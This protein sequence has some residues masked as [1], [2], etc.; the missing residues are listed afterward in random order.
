MFIF[1]C[2]L[3]ISFATEDKPCDKIL[4]LGSDSFD[5]VLASSQVL[6][7]EF[8]AKWCAH[9]R[10]FAP[11]YEVVSTILDEHNN[12]KL[13][14]VNIDDHPDLA[15]RF[16]VD[17][18]PTFKLF[19]KG[20]IID[21]TSDRDEVN[22]A[23]WIIKYSHPII[24]EIHSTE[25]LEGLKQ[26]HQVC[27]IMMGSK[28]SPQYLLFE[29]SAQ[30]S[31]SHCFGLI[32]DSN[33][34][35]YQTK[36]EACILVFKQNDDKFQINVRFDFLD[37]YFESHLVPWVLPLSDTSIKEI[38]IK[39]KTG[40]IVFTQDSQI[41]KLL[42]D[43]T[44]ETYNFFQLTF[45]DSKQALHQVL[46]KELGVDKFEMPFALI[47][48]KQMRKYK[49][50][51]E[52]NF[53]NLKEFCSQYLAGELKEFLRS[54]EEVRKEGSLFRFVGNE[55]LNEV[56]KEK[57]LVAFLIPNCGYCRILVPELEILA[58]RNEGLRVGF[59]DWAA[60]DVRGVQ[61]TEFPALAVFSGQEENALFYDGE[62]RAEDIAKF[63]GFKY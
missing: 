1:I 47:V 27:F 35:N 52:V 21:Y 25:E 62:M 9:C 41:I 6:F 4:D 58:E 63:Y 14:K 45:A 51:K 20:Q 28:S 29:A 42:T 56:R 31:L 3:G 24:Q 18:Y 39:G 44:F 32:Q 15:E 19:T 7:V 50:D 22:M 40:L 30:K 5:E 46:V 49:M 33:I 37:E 36:S 13:A 16:N 57:T 59:V 53:E 12:I 10:K 34:F 23:N 43:L 55:F 8:Y 60:N 54:E 17:S 11:R 38:F 26:L 2:F 48:D 61:V